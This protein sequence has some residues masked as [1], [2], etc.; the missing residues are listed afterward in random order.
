MKY[1]YAKIIGMVIALIVIGCSNVED[2]TPVKSKADSKPPVV[3]MESY[4][5]LFSEYTLTRSN[6][7]N[8]IYMVDTLP[9][10]Y[11]TFGH[12][13]CLETLNIEIGRPYDIKL[14]T[15]NGAVELPKRLCEMT[16]LLK[17]S[18]SM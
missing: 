15:V 16:A 3:T 2:T 11:E 17:A 9:G 6:T 7:R 4:R 10:Q 18:T 1:V 12:A 14:R 13:N 8:Y 5:V